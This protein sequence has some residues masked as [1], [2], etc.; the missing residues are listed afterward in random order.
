MHYFGW[1]AFRRTFS[2]SRFS[3]N[4]T[5]LSV[6]VFSTGTE[7]R[8]KGGETS[9][10]RRSGRMLFYV[11]LEG[12]LRVTKFYGDQEIFLGEGFREISLAR[13]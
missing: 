2:T 13:F 10:A 7:I 11:M 9:F 8:L 5:I 3:G 4:S 12:E 6:R 1:I